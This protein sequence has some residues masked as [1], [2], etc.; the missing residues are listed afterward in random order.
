MDHWAENY[1][2]E[3]SNLFLIKVI[4]YFFRPGQ[5]DFCYA[6]PPALYFIQIEIKISKKNP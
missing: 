4:Y 1:C 3:E 6:G 2:K 5:L